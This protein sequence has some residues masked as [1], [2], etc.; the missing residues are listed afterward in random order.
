ML[1]VKEIYTIV[2]IFSYQGKMI[3]I[4]RKYCG[5]KERLSSFLYR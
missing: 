5:E 2:D 4:E 3:N 1:K